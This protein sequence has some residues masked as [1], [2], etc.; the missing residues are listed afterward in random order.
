MSS[1]PPAKCC[2]IGVKHEA[3]TYFAY[4]SSKSTTNAILLLT[5]VIGHKFINAQLIADQFAANG[6]FVVMPDLFHGDPVKLNAPEGF[7]IMDWLKGHQTGA[8][9]PI[10]DAC[11]KE[12]KG[13]LGV[14]SLGAVGYCFG[15]KYVARFLNQ[16]QIDAGFVAH[17]SFVDDEEIKGMTGPFAIAAAETDQ[18]FPTEKRHHT[19]ELLLKMDIPWQINL[20]SDT[21]HGFAVRADLSK[22]VVKYAKE[23]AFLQAVHWFDEHIKKA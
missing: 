22:P 1:N 9:D 5:D 3:E 16:G 6:Y 13:N 4:P 12:M 2:T 14:K 7:Q 19:E 15:A 21:E 17:P 18:I 11:I 8:V 23:Q 10:V 20:Y